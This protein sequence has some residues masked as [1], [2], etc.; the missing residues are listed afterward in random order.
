[1]VL[2]NMELSAVQVQ[3]LV[4]TRPLPMGGGRHYVFSLYVCLSSVS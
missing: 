1:M 4:I 2:A 3:I